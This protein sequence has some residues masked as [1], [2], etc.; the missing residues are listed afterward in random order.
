MKRP[1]PLK[2]ELLH[3]ILD[4][5]GE[6]GAVKA[7]LVLGSNVVISAP[8]AQHVEQR[9]QALDFLV[10]ADFFLSETAR[11]ADVVLPTAQRAE[12]EGTMTN[13]EGRVIRR[14]AALEP[15]QE[16]PPILTSSASWRAAWAR[17]PISPKPAL[18]ECSSNWTGPAPVVR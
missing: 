5:L 1:C 8:N 17:A 16:C 15:P 4:S 18:R 11:L 13:L 3:E 12:E 10:V 2:S 9:L 14:R 7:L 6:E